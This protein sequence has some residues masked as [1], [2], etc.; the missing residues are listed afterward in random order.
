MIRDIFEQRL[1]GLSPRQ[2]AKTTALIE[3]YRKD[4]AEIQ[5]TAL[6]YAHST[7]PEAARALAIIGQL[8]ETAVGT[9]GSASSIA[10]ANFA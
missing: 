9:L 8:A 7:N 5:E 1:A 4:V 2:E 10:R 6:R 3:E